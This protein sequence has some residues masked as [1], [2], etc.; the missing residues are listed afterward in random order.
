MELDNDIEPI[1]GSLALYDARKRKKITENFYFDLNSL[2]NF[3]FL[4]NQ[5]AE[6]C[7]LSSSCIFSLISGLNDVFI[8]L[9]V[10]YNFLE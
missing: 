6:F 2:D 10:F 4:H 3:P 8:V 5:R 9:K 1:F 7:T